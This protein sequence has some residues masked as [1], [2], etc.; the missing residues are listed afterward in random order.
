MDFQVPPGPIQQELKYLDRDQWAGAHVFVCV[1][2]PP[3]LNSQRY[4]LS[5]TC[6]CDRVEKMTSVQGTAPAP[7]QEV[8]QQMVRTQDESELKR[9][10]GWGCL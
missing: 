3:P 2:L 10:P 8:L 4:H 7:K 6:V 9:L 1:F 5:T